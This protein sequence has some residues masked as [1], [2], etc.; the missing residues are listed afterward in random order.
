MNKEEQNYLNLLRAILERGSQR[1]DR[2]G[3]GTL[4]LFGSRLRFD[5]SKGKVPLLTTK[6]MFTK[7]IIEELLFF[8]RGETDTKKLEAK[9]VKIWSQNTSRQFLDQRNLHDYPEGLMGPMYGYAWRNFGGR[10]STNNPHPNGG[11]GLRDG[12]YYPKTGV[13][14]LSN[15][16][17]LIKNDPYSRRIMIT[18]YDPQASEHSVLDPCHL[19]LQFYVDNGK[20]SC[21]YYQ[22]SVD[23]GLGLPF[24]ILSYAILTGL[25]AKATNLAPGELIFVGGDT[26]IYLSHIDAL[27][28]QISREPFDFSL[29]EITKDI[30]SVED[31]ENM[32]LEDFKFNEYQSHPKLVMSMAS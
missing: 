4:S 7:G 9:G 15:C 22:R 23:C 3:V 10:Y 12:V 25:M 2:T 1:M 26:H 27:K 24:N 17:N 28:E 6:K 29:M 8:I 16:F 5:L 20:L 18:A 32:L 30:S 19:F 31:M 13:D 11:H 14:Q 21:Q